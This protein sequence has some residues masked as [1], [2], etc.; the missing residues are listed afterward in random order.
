MTEVADVIWPNNQQVPRYS[1]GAIATVLRDLAAW[2]EEEKK[3]PYSADTLNELGNSL[4]LRHDHG[5]PCDDES[6]PCFAAGYK[7][8]AET[9]DA[10]FAARNARRSE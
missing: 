8:R 9:R 1:L 5:D 7:A 6:C 4:D 3:H 2:T 10:Y